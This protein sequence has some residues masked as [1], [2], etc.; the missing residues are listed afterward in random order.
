VRASACK[1]SRIFTSM[2]SNS[3]F[4]ALSHYLHELESLILGSA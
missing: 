1:M 2:A 3:I 4:K